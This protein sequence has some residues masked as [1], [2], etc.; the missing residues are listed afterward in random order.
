[1]SESSVFILGAGASAEAQAPLMGDFLRRAEDL[2]RTG[3]P[4]NAHADFERVARAQAMLQH[5]L[6]KAKLDITN[7]E[8]VFA[9]FEM[10]QLF[11]S[12]GTLPQDDVRQLLTSM[13]RVIVETLDRSMKYHSEQVRVRESPFDSRLVHQIV[14][15]P[16]YPKFARLV[17]K[18]REAGQRVSLITFNYDIAVDVSL[19]RVGEDFDYGL[20][21]DLE[22]REK[23]PLLKLHGSLNWSGCSKPGCRTVRPRLV[24]DVIQ[25]I[26]KARRE[27]GD[28][29]EGPIVTLDVASSLPKVQHCD[30]PCAATPVIVPPTFSKGGYQQQLTP[31]WRRAA[32]CLAEADNVF[33]IGYSWP[34]GDHFFHQLYALGSV[35][36][37]L[38]RRFWVFNPDPRVLE[39]FR[40]ELLGQLALGAFGPV[41]PTG[42]DRL[43]PTDFRGAITTLCDVFRID[44]NQLR[45]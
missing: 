10:A 19:W 17:K 1:M 23:L 24:R 26:E 15:P 29:R 33:V 27:R 13:Q 11:G 41:E 2:R 9:A 35:G 45:A 31:V 34:R 12:L 38:T 21:D 3:A 8:T 32:A 5:V 6:A 39:R 20:D 16:P 42:P 14:A 36:E 44:E 37:R 18:L 25:D 28:T 43:L 4:P 7:L 22:G 40:D 30:Q